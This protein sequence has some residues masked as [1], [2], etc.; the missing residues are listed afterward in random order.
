M[1]ALLTIT[2]LTL[3]CAT[4]LHVTSQNANATTQTASWQQSLAGAEGAVDQAMSELNERALNE[5]A[6]TGWYTVGGTL[7]TSKPAGGIAATGFPASG[8]YNYYIP[9]TLAVSSP[10]SGLQD[11]SG[12]TVATWVT[13]DTA[14][15]PPNDPAQKVKQAYRIRATGVVGAPGPA[16]VSNQ[17]LD[18]ELR[19]ISLRYDRFTGTAVTTPQAARRIEVIAT[20]VV[21]RDGF[22]FLR[23]I[24]TQNWVELT[25]SGSIVDSFDSSNPFKSTNKLYDSTKRQSNGDI[26]LVSSS[27][28]NSVSNIRGNDVYGSLQYSGPAVKNTSGVKGTVSTPF[29]TTLPPT[30]SPTWT[31]FTPYTSSPNNSSITASSITKN[32]P[33]RYKVTGNFSLQQDFAINAPVPPLP[34]PGQPVL[35]PTQHYI[36]IWVT[37]NYTTTGNAL[38]TQSPNVH[39]TWHVDG[40]ISTAGNAYVNQSNVASNLSFIAIGSGSITIAGNGALIGTFYGPQRDVAF[41]GNASLFGAV[42]GDNLKLSSGASIHY[43]EALGSVDTFNSPK[44]S[45]YAYASWFED[46][47]DPARNIIY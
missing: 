38:V 46:N 11:E 22:S 36:E 47:S 12:K 21:T 25:G 31:T 13:V 27:K 3:I 39:V 16:R 19:K 10:A 30:S 34:L 28:N 24:T 8:S 9:P 43:D 40:N 2:I 1:V 18:N 45:N 4:S 29:N 35:P 23:A 17:K 33:T 37:G 15:L 20:P 14:G 32:D 44:F 5:G 42:V 26:G 7:P 6:W 41:T